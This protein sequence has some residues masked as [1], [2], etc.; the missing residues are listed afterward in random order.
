MA[1]I[2]PIALTAISFKFFYVFV[3]A[4]VLAALCYL[5]LFPEYVLRS[6]QYNHVAKLTRSLRRTSRLTL[7]QMN[8]LF[9]DMEIEPKVK[10]TEVWIDSVDKSVA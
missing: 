4:D 2:S 1:Q 9:G 5:L 10:G 7:E 6:Y 3:A 8:Q